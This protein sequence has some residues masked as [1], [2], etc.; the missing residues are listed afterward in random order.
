MQT[1]RSLGYFLLCDEPIVSTNHRNLLLCYYPT[2]ID[3][4]LGGHKVRKVLRWVV[5]NLTCYPMTR[6]T[7]FLRLSE[8]HPISYHYQ[9][10]FYL[11]RMVGLNLVLVLMYC[12]SRN[13]RLLPRVAMAIYVWLR[14]YCG[15]RMMHMSCNYFGQAGHIGSESTESI[16]RERYTWTTLSDDTRTFVAD[17]LHSLMENTGNKIHR[18]CLHVRFPNEV[19]H[20]YYL[21]MGL[22][23]EVYKYVFVT[24]DDL[25]S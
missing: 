1:F 3:P 9:L 15:Y 7:K 25:S 23:K 19:V 6:I 14:I 24:K 21:F 17:C 18:P 5:C 12:A 22:S 20:F 4:T 8:T 11:L 16:L 10:M 13:F 2:A